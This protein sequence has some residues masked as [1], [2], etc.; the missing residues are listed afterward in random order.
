MGTA[1]ISRSAAASLHGSTV[2]TNY[3]PFTAGL[4]PGPLDFAGAAP[5]TQPAVQNA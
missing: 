5:A 1:V 4:S 3:V 2:S